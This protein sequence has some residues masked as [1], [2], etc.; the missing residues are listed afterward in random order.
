MLWPFSAV[1]ELGCK[2]RGGCGVIEI[3]RMGLVFLM[4]GFIKWY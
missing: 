4:F 3:P 1:V 2:S